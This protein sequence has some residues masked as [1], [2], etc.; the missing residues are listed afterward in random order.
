M[1]ESKQKRID[2]WGFGNRDA[3]SVCNCG[4]DGMIVHRPKT[5]GVQFSHKELERIIACHNAC[6]GINPEAV[7][8]LLK[9]L[10]ISVHALAPDNPE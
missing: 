4:G 7:P 5:D 8:D 10:Q 9:A 1:T 2:T 6:L 3:D